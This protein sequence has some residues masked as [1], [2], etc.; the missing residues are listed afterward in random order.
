[1]KGKPTHYRWASRDGHFKTRWR[2]WPKVEDFP[3]PSKMAQRRLG[4]G[5]TEK[6]QCIDAN[7]RR[8]FNPNR[9]ELCHGT[10]TKTDG[11]R[12]TR[13]RFPFQSCRRI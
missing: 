8:T 4:G 13:R 11:R 3:K 7:N 10:E 2:P 1:M 9:L 5:Y 6:S 12:N